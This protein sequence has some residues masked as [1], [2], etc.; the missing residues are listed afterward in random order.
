MKWLLLLIAVLAVG[1]A[2][3][4]SVAVL[5]APEG[6]EMLVDEDLEVIGRGDRSFGYISDL[7]ADHLR[8]CHA[9]WDFALRSMSRNV[10]RDSERLQRFFD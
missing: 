1:C 7:W 9:G 4:T 8:D 2:S 10:R 3:T 6:M 5:E